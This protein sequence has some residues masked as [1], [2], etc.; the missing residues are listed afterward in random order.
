MSTAM[1][2]DVLIRACP[3]PFSSARVD[4]V[5]PEGSSLEEAVRQAVPMLDELREYVHAS[6]DGIPVP[7][8]DWAS[9]EL[10]AGQLVA[11]RALPSGKK[12]W[13]SILTIA[14]LAWAGAAGARIAGGWGWGAV[15]K[16]IVSGALTF[17]ALAIV[18]NLV[19]PPGEI[20][21]QVS[22]LE[23]GTY[24]IAGARNRLRPY[25]V[26]PLVLGRH[27]VTPPY[28]AVP[29]TE[30]LG[31]EQ[32]LRLLFLVGYG[33]VT[34]SDIKIGDTPID[35]YS[36]VTYEVFEGY[37][38]DGQ[39][40]IYQGDVAEKVVGALLTQAGGWVTRTADTLDSLSV[41]IEF[42]G[43]LCTY[44]N[45]VRGARGVTVEVQVA[46]AGSGAWVAAGSFVSS[47]ATAQPY[48]RGMKNTP[49]LRG[50][51]DIRMRRTTADTADPNI[52]DKVYWTV[53]REFLWRAPVDTTY[54]VA[55]IAVRIRASNQ[56]S[57]IVDQLNC[58]AESVVPDWA[59]GAWVDRES[60]NPAALYRRLLQGPANKRPINDSRIDLTALQAW[61]VWCE[62]QG[63]KFNAVL[64][65]RRTLFECL[66]LV[67]AAGRASPAFHDGK[68]SIV[69][70]VAQTTPIQLF[71]PR[72]SRNFTGSRTF[73]DQ[74]D[75]LKVRWL[76]EDNEFRQEEM[77][78]YDG[79]QD[80][81]SATNFET[82]S[83]FGVTNKDL[84]W[85]HARFHLACTRLRPESFSIETDVEHMV[86]SRGDL[87]K[88]THD[89]PLLG[90]AS[91]RVLHTSADRVA[92][93][94]EC[95]MVAG[96]T[97]GLLGRKGDGTITQWKL[98]THAGT[99]T[100]LDR[101][102]TGAAFDVA[103]GDMVVFGEWDSESLGC[104]VN[105]IEMLPDL[106]ARLHLIPYSAAVYTAD[107]GV[108]PEY[109][110]QLSIPF[111]M[112]VATPPTD[113]A[114][115]E[116]LYAEGG[117]VKSGATLAWRHPSDQLT[118]RYEIECRRPNDE[119]TPV[120][121]CSSDMV[122]I[123]DTEPGDWDFRVRALTETRTG[124]WTE[125]L[126]QALVGLLADLDDVENLRSAFRAGKTVLVWDP[127]TDV[128][129][130][131]YE[132]RYGTVWATATVA[133][134]PT[135]PEIHPTNDGTYLV[136]A[137]AG[138]AYSTNA[139]SLLIENVLSG[140]NALVTANEHPD[141]DGF[142]FGSAMR[143]EWPA[144]FDVEYE[145][146]TLP[147]IATP[148]WTLVGNEQ[149]SIVT[150]HLLKITDSLA[151]VGYYQRTIGGGV[152]E[153]FVWSKLYVNPGTTYTPAFYFGCRTGTH[154]ARVYVKDG[155]VNIL[156]TGPTFVACDT[157][158][159]D[160]PRSFVLRVL[161][162]TYT[163]WIDGIVKA[164][165]PAFFDVAGPKVMFGTESGAAASGE[166]AHFDFV[167]YWSINVHESHEPNRR[168]WVRG[169]YGLS[170][171]YQIPTADQVDLG[172]DAICAVSASTDYHGA[173]S[174][175]DLNLI[176]DL[177][178][179]EDLNV[180][181]A[182]CSV[183]TEIRTKPDGGSW[184]A[185]APLINGEYLA[186]YFDFRLNVVLADDTI[187]AI[188]GEFTWTVDMPD[189]IEKL[190]GEAIGAA[191]KAYLWT[192]KFQITPS[193]QV[194]V[195]S[196]TAGDDVLLTAESVNGFTVQVKN[197]GLGVARTI[198][199]VAIGY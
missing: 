99:H 173:D 55:L 73:H 31:S 196:A 56:L 135:D 114:V 6:V 43:G 149:G 68:H 2:N 17:G 22:E 143:E 113:L 164:T 148:A 198:N 140:E 112:R 24:S 94:Q 138:D 137:R 16:G 157:T 39:S 191:G 104:L 12:F 79:D 86:C 178:L 26:V 65:T 105:S 167:R 146:C 70:D 48:R 155:E 71:T 76:N 4:G 162:S 184:G 111:E 41:D 188:I 78:V 182:E 142:F 177:N 7:E 153:I 190:P 197:G 32:Y 128:R 92:L 122:Q 189:R 107:T 163:L 116:Y 81:S 45:G 69:R 101:D 103:R 58:I 90:L 171:V 130:V 66:K 46:P 83:F 195:V 166:I 36:D 23:A 53:Y 185:W 118:R 54:D 144:D 159:A 117:L 129:A 165:G 18:N 63:Y 8:R 3:H 35:S 102:P 85:K 154:M 176:A 91:G 9:T 179:E 127:V 115:T 125:L 30:V 172:Y 44:V 174:D 50:P 84:V 98:L 95:T 147:P 74:P 42:P 10:R 161:V 106:A 109:V 11:I 97:Y 77:I 75:G 181:T 28:A 134:T 133:D 49:T 13:R 120:G 96:K 169:A 119:W 194:T 64:D 20:P 187:T 80:E 37:P 14:V 93:D 136:K 141:W 15:G 38:T 89:V 19:P 199:I 33:P 160:D 60:R 110:P 59:G 156:G 168:V 126:A 72:N 47:Q 27:L 40:Q 29:Y 100:A 175:N 150:P 87:V 52:I 82:V 67:A 25:G 1:G 158:D 139:A 51:Q 62:A 121:F 61:H 151:A 183:A 5:A 21:G 186:R 131:D 152:G 123:P 57:G 124:N 34:I 132:V 193:T 145:G 180:G 170:G 88:L 192:P 108:I